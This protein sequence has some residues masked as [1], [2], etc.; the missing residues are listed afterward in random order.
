MGKDIH[1]LISDLADGDMN[2]LEELYDMISL[3]IFNYARSITKNK[4]MAEDITHD[5]YLQIYKQ[6]AHIAE[7]SNPTAYIMAV[8]RNHSYNLLKRS[9]KITVSLD[10][11]LEISDASLPYDSLIFKDAFLS[12]P[13][14]QRETVHLHLICG[15]TLKDIAKLQKVPLVTV[16]WR[17]GKALSRLRIYFVQDTKE[18]NYNGNL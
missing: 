17:Y 9:N 15:Y 1:E 7:I 11:A 14:N 4:E 6:A 3:R 10:D 2:A 12:L 8:T 13:P 18:E 5:V 16:K